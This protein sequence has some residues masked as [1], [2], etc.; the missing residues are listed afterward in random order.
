M[1]GIRPSS[2]S[3]PPE[4]GSGTI[5]ARGLGAGAAAGLRHE[6]GGG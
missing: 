5:A 6:L 3:D 1:S 2:P 4:T